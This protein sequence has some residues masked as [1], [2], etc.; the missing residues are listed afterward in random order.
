M[1]VRQLDKSQL[2]ITLQVFSGHTH[3]YERCRRT[4]KFEHDACAPTYV[5]VG[6]GGNIEGVCPLSALSLHCILSLACR[7]CC[8]SSF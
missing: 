8:H 2:C 6:D 1:R 4:Y 7:V 3:A 5:T